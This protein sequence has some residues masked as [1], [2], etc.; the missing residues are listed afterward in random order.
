MA[1]KNQQGF[2]SRTDFVGMTETSFGNVAKTTKAKIILTKT[3][4][5]LDTDI[6]DAVKP[7]GASWVTAILKLQDKNGNE[8][9]IKDL[10]VAGDTVT[11]AVSDA[12]ALTLQGEILFSLHLTDDTGG[13]DVC[14]GDFTYGELATDDTV[15]S[16][17][18]E[19]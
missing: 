1:R 7:S 3:A 4:L 2:Y 16:I 11:T 17:G 8:P 6:S 13:S 14:V 15:R 5:G 9:V 12:E 18:N 19:A 10:S